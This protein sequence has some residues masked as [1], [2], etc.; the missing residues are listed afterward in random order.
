MKKSDTTPLAYSYAEDGKLY[1]SFHWKLVEA[2]YFN[3]IGKELVNFAYLDGNQLY[4]VMLKLCGDYM[5]LAENQPNKD[6]VAD[7]LLERY[8]PWFR[9]NTYFTVYLMSF[10]D[11]LIDGSPDERVFPGTSDADQELRK[12]AESQQGDAV[13]N[14]IAPIF[15]AF[16][17]KRELAEAALRVIYEDK[18]DG[19]TPVERYYR[20]EQED[21]DFQERLSATF[22]VTLG[23]R[24]TGDR[25]VTQLTVLDTVDDLLRYELFLL[26]TQGKGY[27][28]C[29]NC[30]KPFI[31]S[32]RS[33]T[34][35]CDR[36]MDG[37]DKPCSEIGAYLADVKKVAS[38]PVLS[39][40][41]KAYQRLHKRVEL[42]YMEDD[43]FARW[44]DEAAQKRDR[45]MAG[46]LDA[47][48]FLAWV[49]ATSR[50][51]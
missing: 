26:A 4:S 20:H 19:L 37:A 38:D 12:I 22:T 44:K 6:V 27:K 36:V 49:D 15:D 21:P 34:V 10:L 33:D 50:R 51:R 45:C 3:A 43:E 48:E 5:L 28:Y 9:K 35:Y 39:A 8:E 41:R 11:Y 42:G 16:Q 47:E 29:K 30:G 14:V 24:C 25:S 18:A 23:R 2:D 17:S 32:G 1:T 46:E 31:P 13:P 7:V 40:Y